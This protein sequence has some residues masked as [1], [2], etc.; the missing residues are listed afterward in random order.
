MTT[1]IAHHDVKD[2]KKWLASPN[3]KK[4]FGP[5]GVTGIREFIDPQNPNRVAVLMEVP[6]MNR[7]MEAMKTPAAAQA[8][9]EDGVLPETMVILLGA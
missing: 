4:F 9:A 6:D 8:M 5:L 7:V 2:S 3:R 1:V